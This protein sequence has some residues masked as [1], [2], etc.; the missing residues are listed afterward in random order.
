MVPAIITVDEEIKEESTKF[1]LV[2][3]IKV[4]GVPV[5]VRT[6]KTKSKQETR[7]IG[8]SQFP[9]QLQYVD[10]DFEDE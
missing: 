5:F 10:D 9:D 7:A 6:Q 4:F 8:F 1:T 3:T 2:K